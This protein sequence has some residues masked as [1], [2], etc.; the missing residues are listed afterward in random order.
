MGSTLDALMADALRLSPAERSELI[1]RLADSMLPPAPLHPAW[2]DEL[3]R[4]VAEMDSGAVESIPA[5]QVLAQLRRL[6]DSTTAP[7]A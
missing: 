1:G 4:R 2:D 6:S 7:K 3:A 5:E